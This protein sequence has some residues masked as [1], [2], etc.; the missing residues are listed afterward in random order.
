MSGLVLCELI[1]FY[2]HVK[3]CLEI[4]KSPMQIDTILQTWYYQP[5]PKCDVILKTCPDLS[6]YYDTIWYDSKNMSRLVKILWFNL[7]RCL[8]LSKTKR[9]R[10]T[11]KFEWMTDKVADEKAI[12]WI[13]SEA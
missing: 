12:P 3:T 11:Q 5:R 8:D 13:A 9:W 1:C 6:K 10:N 4:L 2:R 7:I